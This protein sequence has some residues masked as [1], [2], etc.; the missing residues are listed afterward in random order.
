ML[1]AQ[2]N[3]TYSPTIGFLWQKP[4]VPAWFRDIVI[5]N[6]AAGLHVLM[7]ACVLQDLSI[8]N[9]SLTSMVLHVVISVI[10]QPIVNLI[11]IVLFFS[12]VLM[13]P[14]GFDVIKKT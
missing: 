6:D 5:L 4:A 13:P 7:S 10:T 8:V 14:K 12:V 9:Q 3:H 2:T 1:K 11:H